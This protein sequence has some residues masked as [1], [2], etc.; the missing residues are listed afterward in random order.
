MKNFKFKFDPIN[1]RGEFYA[2]NPYTDEILKIVKPEE[3]GNFTKFNFKN[4]P[5]LNKVEIWYWDPHLGE[6]RITTIINLHSF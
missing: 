4:Y 5:Y 1:L 3:F 2:R 6:K